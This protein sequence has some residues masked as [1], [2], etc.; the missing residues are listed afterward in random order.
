MH[1]ATMKTLPASVSLFSVILGAVVCMTFTPAGFSADAAAPA[2]TAPDK[3]AL[4]AQLEAREK[5]ADF[6]LDEL[7]GSDDRIEATV[8]RILETLRMVGDSKDS[9]TKVARLKEM[10]I[11]GLQRNIAYYQ[12][13]RGSL[14]EEMRR[15]T[16]HLTPEEKQRAIAKFDSRIEKRVG[17]ILALT[18]SLPTHKDYERYNTVSDGWYGT[19]SVRNKDFEQNRRLT[20]HTNTQ[21]EE[22]LKELQRSIER[23]DRQIRTLQTQLA[24]ATNE[25]HRNILYAEIK[26]SEELLQSRR[27]QV[28]EA[29]TPYETATRPVSNKEA[30]D[31][32]MALRRAIESLRRDFGTLFQRYSAYLTERSNVN[33]AKAALEAMK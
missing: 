10:T 21:R 33:A 13:K 25:A 23:I 16:L 26:K 20:A 15:P 4:K 18:Q 29:A 11:D 24:A 28:A 22:V 9:R 31:L 8:D 32:D 6:L 12:Q 2:P 27:A 17:Q 14:Q 5:R 30:Q 7:R 1:S 19:T 3:A